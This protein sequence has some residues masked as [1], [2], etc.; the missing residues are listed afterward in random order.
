MKLGRLREALSMFAHVI[1][2]IPADDDM[3]AE[4]R[5]SYVTVVR[6]LCAQLASSSRCGGAI[7]RLSFIRRAAV[8][9]CSSKPFSHRRLL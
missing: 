8:G 7:L 5:N 2:T 1:A 6:S 9:R 3:A 4:A